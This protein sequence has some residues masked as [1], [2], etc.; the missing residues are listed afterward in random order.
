MLSASIRQL[1][2]H[3]SVKVKGVKRR[4]A[5]SALLSVAQLVRAF[6]RGFVTSERTLCLNRGPTVRASAFGGPNLL[7][8][9][10]VAWSPWF[11]PAPSWRVCVQ[12]NLVRLGIKCASGACKRS[13]GLQAQL[14]QEVYLVVM[15]VFG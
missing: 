8:T 9:G 3:S 4:C 1:H 14:Q 6:I 13:A 7:E 11:E 10:I 2:T 15:Y 12:Y 5:A